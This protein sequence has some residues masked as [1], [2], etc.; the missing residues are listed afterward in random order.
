MAR[1]PVEALLRLRRLT[2]DEARRDLAACLDEEIAA[3]AKA[4][5]VADEIMR[6][7]AAACRLEATDQ[8][9]ESFAAWLHR[10]R[11]AAQAADAALETA[12]M[13]TSEARAVLA[14]ARAA[15]EAA[16]Q[17]LARQHADQQAAAAQQ[18]QRVLDEAAGRAAAHPDRAA[19]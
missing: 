1:N 10:M 9:V 15:A 5:A 18:E 6:E 14:A 12:V 19:R 11:P 3:Q 17:L 16:E 7:T 2:V 13:H 8:A 4:R